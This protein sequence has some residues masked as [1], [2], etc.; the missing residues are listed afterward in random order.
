MESWLYEDID[1]KGVM[2]FANNCSN[3]ISY[4]SEKD[5]VSG[6]HPAVRLAYKEKHC[7]KELSSIPCT[8]EVK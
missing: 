7:H 8:V 3:L 5:D 6:M 2:L 4:G 1:N